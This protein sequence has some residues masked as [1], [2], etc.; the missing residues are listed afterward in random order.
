[1]RVAAIGQP[2]G[3]FM[4]PSNVAHRIGINAYVT[5]ILYVF[6]NKLV[7]NIMRIC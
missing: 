6:T 3:H 7:E 1:M 2:L 5:V 4:V